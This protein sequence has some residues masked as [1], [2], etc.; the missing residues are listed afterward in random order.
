MCQCPHCQGKKLK[1]NVV[2]H[3]IPHKGDTKLFWKRD[4]LQSM[5]KQCHDIFKQSQE[6]GGRGFDQG[7]DE[8]GNPLNQLDHWK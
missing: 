4:N 3:I 8:Q 2:D 5:N 6:K 7:C 1:A